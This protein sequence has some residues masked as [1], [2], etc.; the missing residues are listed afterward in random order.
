MRCRSSVR[1]ASI[2]GVIALC[3]A[4][5][6]AAKFRV[7]LSVSTTHPRVGQTVEVVIRTGEP[8]T[9]GCRMR[10][11]AIA[12]GANRQTALDALV[13]GGTTTMATTGP[14]FHRVRA[15][16]KLGFVATT[17]RTSA[18]AWQA[19]VRFPRPGAWQLVVPNWC[20]PGYAS[21]LPAVRVLVVR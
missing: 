19:D 3:L 11:A 10:L 8:T 20:A 7:S 15:T 5:A 16:P 14:M 4:P 13:N 1:F 9:R 12:P 6:A 2:L 18:V 21:P 17:L